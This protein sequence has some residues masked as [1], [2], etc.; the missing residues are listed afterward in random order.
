[1]RVTVDLDYPSQF[2]LLK[3]YFN[4]KQLGCVEICESS[5]GKGYHLI[6]NGLP[7]TP[8]QSIELR[9]WLGDDQNRIHFD[10]HT[11]KHKPKQI[12]FTK[13]ENRKIRWID[14]KNLTAQPFAS[15]LCRSFFFKK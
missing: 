11:H 2:Q 14:E 15:K 5:G 7:I 8:Q 13:K 10:E 6:V 9:R 12:L 3:T 1:M 4:M